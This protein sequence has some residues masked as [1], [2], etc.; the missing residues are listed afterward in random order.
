MSWCTLDSLTKSINWFKDLSE[1]T[2]VTCFKLIK[3]VN[4]D[5]Y[6]FSASSAGTISIRFAFKTIELRTM[7]EPRGVCSTTFSTNRTNKLVQSL[8]RVSISE[9]AMASFFRLAESRV[10]AANPS[11]MSFR[12]SKLSFF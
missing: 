11:L 2:G 10:S 4:I 12:F 5:L 9:L 7:T 3:W 6:F 8:R 1:K